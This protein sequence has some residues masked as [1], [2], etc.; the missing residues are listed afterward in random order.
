MHCSAGAS[1]VHPAAL[2]RTIDRRDQRNA[3]VGNEC[4]QAQ[5]V[6]RGQETARRAG[7]AAEPGIVTHHFTEDDLTLYYYGEG[8]GRH[9]IERHLESCAGCAATYREIA[10]TLAMVAAPGVPERGDQYG[11][12]VWQRIRHKLPER[13]PSLWATLSGSAPSRAARVR[14]GRRDA[15]PRGVRRGPRLAATAG[16]GHAAGSGIARDCRRECG[17]LEPATAV[18][19]SS[20]RRWRI[21][22]IDPS[23][24]SPTS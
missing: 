18:T 10:G 12:E 23:A 17:G 7:A 3:R 24:C 8:R 2:R 5:R 6:S 21:T 22:S 13:Q 4:G 9:E 11:L 20:S 14:G 16:G 19:A 15:G 1:G